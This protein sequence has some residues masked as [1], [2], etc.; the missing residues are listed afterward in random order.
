MREGGR[1]AFARGRP[2][3][4]VIVDERWM[5]LSLE[6]AATS[7]PHPNPRVGAVVVDSD[8]ALAGRGSHVGPGTPH[9][10]FL[11]LEE[12]G[13]RARGATLYVTLE[14]C[15]HYGRTPPCVDAIL[16]AGI[17]RVVV[18]IVDPDPRVSGRGLERLEDAGVEVVLG[19]EE[20]AAQRLDPGYFSHRRTG[21]PWVILKAAATLDGQVAA[22]DGTSKWITSD[23]AR[24]DAHE[25][26]AEV[27]AV[28][29]GAGTVRTD[30]PLLDVRLPDYAGP[31][32][33][34]VIVAG[35]HPL[36]ADARVLSRDPIVLRSE[37]S[38]VDL[39]E[40]LRS[41]ADKGLLHILVEGGPTLAASLLQEGLVNRVVLYLAPSLAGGTGY[42]LF[43]AA[44]HTLG[45]AHPVRIT[46]IDRVGDA[47]K[48]DAFVEEG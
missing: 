34:P 5:T 29:V 27:D 23:V 4:K 12:A 24:Q 7:R 16:A 39:T 1:C 40:G 22:T 47:I 28:V 3:R 32:P 46:A 36:P 31:Q 19:I 30:D 26:R 42:G 41:L 9:A 48:I 25:L 10:E 15:V 35:K 44:F 33:V 43:N 45:D 6:L 2:V 37:G 14:P 13:D 21:L 17:S 38:P 20:E 11:A 18:A 8:G